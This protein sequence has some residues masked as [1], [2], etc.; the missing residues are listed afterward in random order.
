MSVVFDQVYYINMKKD[1]ER[2]ENMKKL[3]KQ[4][5][6]NAKR[7]EGIEVDYRDYD[8][9]TY[10]NFN[11]RDEKYLNGQLGCRE[12]H[13]NAVKDAKANNYKRVLIFEDDVWCDKKLDLNT[14]IK[15][16]Y[17]SLTIGDINFLGGHV[18][19]NYRNQ[20]VCAHAYTL[21]NIVYDDIINMGIASGMEIDN[22]YAKIIQHMSVNKYGGKYIVNKIYPFNTFKQNRLYKSNISEEEV[23]DPRFTILPDEN[24]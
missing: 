7:I 18:E 21:S 23:T 12:A 16:N 8:E 5:N 22:F 24:N 20:I 19:P 6:V 15:L 11:K 9:S 17:F 1:V 13:L 10:R 3:L 4:L 2:N 14:Y